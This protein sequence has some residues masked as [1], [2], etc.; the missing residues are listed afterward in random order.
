MPAQVVHLPPQPPAPSRADSAAV[1]MLTALASVLAA[2][3]LLLLSVVFGFVLAL[4]A[5]HEQSWASL[6][7]LGVYACLT[8]LPLVYLDLK[9][10]VR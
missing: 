1:G 9:T 2:R 7:I 3:L 10:R 5:M 8:V 4:Y 6:A